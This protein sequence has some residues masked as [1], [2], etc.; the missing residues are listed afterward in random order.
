MRGPFS[1]PI[2]TK[3]RIG[4]FEK[5][6][7]VP[8]PVTFPPMTAD[9]AADGNHAG[10]A[11]AAV[12]VGPDFAGYR[13]TAIVFFVDIQALRVRCGHLVSFSINERLQAG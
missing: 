1:A 4:P 3:L 13:E 9:I 8:A 10:N 6:N 2:G 11:N 7:R 5:R 12:A